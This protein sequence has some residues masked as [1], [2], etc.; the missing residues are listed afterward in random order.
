MTPTRLLP[1]PRPATTLDR[2]RPWNPYDWRG[3]PAAQ[4]PPWPNAGE[5]YTVRDLLADL[6]ALTTPADALSLTAALGQVQSRQAFL[7]QGGDCAEPFGKAAV[8]GARAKDRVIGAMAERIS[9]ALGLPTVTIGRIAGQFA[10]PRSANTEK[11]DGREL[12]VFRGLTVNGPEPYEKDRRPDPYRLMSGYYSGKLVLHELHMLAHEQASARLPQA[13]EPEVAR[14]LL[15]DTAPALAWDGSLHSVLSGYGRT[16]HDDGPGG[17]RWSHTGLWTSHES[18]VLDYE[19]PL[20]RRDPLTGEWYLLSTHLPWIGER[21]R[22][23]NGAHVRFLSGIANPVACKIG[24]SA[25]PYDVVEL[26]ERLDPLRKP[27]RLSLIVRMGPAQLRDHLP[28][29]VE[30]VRA[31][32]HQVVWVSDPMHGNTVQS[33]G[34]LK[35]RYLD[36]ILAEITAFF[37]I[38]SAAGEWPGGVHLELAGTDVTECVGGELVPT[39]GELPLRYSSM[40][41]P[42]LNN[43]QALE[44]AD[45]IARLAS[46]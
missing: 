15:P 17:G 25:T 13:W 39:E 8:A 21:T 40:C 2:D 44:V 30:A 23:P 12:P 28:G 26:C 16:R 34:G 35:T 36:A 22:D 46:A 19:A 1:G 7:V 6:P 10:K 31:A 5:L 29:I 38:L 37:R 9:A 43:E 18:L 27:G 11:V 20:T 33:A 14:A 24:P 3:L 41:D 4:Q 45:L 42:R 32:G